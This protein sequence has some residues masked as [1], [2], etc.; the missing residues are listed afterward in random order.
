MFVHLVPNLFAGFVRFPI[1][2]AKTSLKTLTDSP[3]FSSCPLIMAQLQTVLNK[4]LDKAGKDPRL[5]P[6][7]LREKA[8]KTMALQA[9]QLK[10][11][12]DQI[13]DLIW[14]WHLEAQR[15]ENE[16][17]VTAMRVLAKLAK[18]S[19]NAPAVF[20]GLKELDSD[21]ERVI[22]LRKR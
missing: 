5:T 3:A 1:S 4:L 22:E 11:Q 7:L 12:R 17:Q 10:A 13:K 16:A 19:G 2:R 15:K 18:V 9:G 6:R 20:K 21:Q 8:E 14:E